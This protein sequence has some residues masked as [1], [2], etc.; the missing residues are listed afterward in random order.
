MV[1]IQIILHMYL[2]LGGWKIGKVGKIIQKATLAIFLTT[3][4]ICLHS[5]AILRWFQ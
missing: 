5:C 2:V 3:G 4:K 1:N